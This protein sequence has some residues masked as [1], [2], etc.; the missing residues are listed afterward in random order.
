[1]HLFLRVPRHCDI[2]EV[3]RFA[4]AVEDTCLDRCAV[5]DADD[6]EGQ[7]DRLVVVGR[8]REVVLI[9]QDAACFYAEV[10]VIHIPSGITH[11]AEVDY[12]LLWNLILLGCCDPCHAPFTLHA[13]VAHLHIIVARFNLYH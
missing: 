5:G 11:H 3:S 1:M 12:P 13:S 10:E 6:H 9:E 4:C 2:V 8:Q 7:V